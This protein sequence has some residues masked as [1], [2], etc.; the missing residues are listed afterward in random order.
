MITEPPISTSA[1]PP[2]SDVILQIISDLE[3]KKQTETRQVEILESKLASSRDRIRQLTITIEAL[4]KEYNIGNKSN[5]TA[6]A[7]GNFLPLRYGRASNSF[8][9]YNNIGP[10]QQP[11]FDDATSP[12]VDGWSKPVSVSWLDLAREAIRGADNLL[13]PSEISNYLKMDHEAKRKHGQT[14]SGILASYRGSDHIVGVPVYQ[15]TAGGKITTQ[16]LNGLPEFFQNLEAKKLKPNYEAK[17]RD[18]VKG[19]GLF[20]TEE[21]AELS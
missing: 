3:A 1:P 17:L 6:I 10:T 21:E 14:L 7:N 16:F 4:K 9:L 18:K 19:L 15:K 5:K 13:T 8:N 2:S 11:I 12:V 20:L